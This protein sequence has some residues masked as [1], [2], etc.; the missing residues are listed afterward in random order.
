MA[1][2][3]GKHIVVEKPVTQKSVEAAELV[4]L[5]KE[6]GL[7]F[8]VFQNRRWDGDFMTVQKILQEMKLG[9]LIEF[10]S[11]YDRYRT[12]I[13]PDT[14]KEETDEYGGV[15]YNLG[16]HMI[17]QAYVLFGKP[18]AV[19]A[20]LK[21]VRTGGAVTDY[22]DIR[23]EY[24]GFSAILKCSY[25]V[26]NPGPRYSVY[27]E[28]GTFY[29]N[30]IDP[31]EELMK[32]GNLPVGDD[33][34]SEPIDEWGTIVYVEN[35]EKIEELVK[36]IPGNYNIFYNNVY[37]AIRKGKEL[38]VKPGDTVEVLKIIEACVESNREK[39]TV[40]LS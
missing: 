12:A 35:G 29:K 17:D 38:F 26:K 13:T 1:L 39:R 2:L 23:F 6:K 24:K 37:D 15:L 9:R 27:G 4:R 20:H 11:H 33:W 7:V 14:W 36:T 40:F 30:G 5:A 22:Y 32:A 34:G 19:T 25:L 21:I 31:Q 8:T 28:Y 10:E 16:S 3:A 18:I